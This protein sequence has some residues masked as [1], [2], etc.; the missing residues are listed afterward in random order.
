MSIKFAATA[1][2]IL[3]S[4]LI[5]VWVYAAFSKLMDLGNFKLVLTSS[6]LIGSFAYGIA[7]GLPFIE[8]FI[9]A[10][11]FVPKYRLRGFAASLILMLLLTGYLGYMILFVPHLPCSCGGILEKI[12][13]TQH[14]FFNITLTIIAAVGLLIH[15]RN[16]YLIAINTR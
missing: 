16:K 1:S 10:L 14:L 12:S 15:Q 6:P 13:W 3:S 11:L 8:L 4:V 5:L 9:T 2:E 7:V